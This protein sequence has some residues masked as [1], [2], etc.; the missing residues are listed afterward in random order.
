MPWHKYDLLVNSIRFKQSSLQSPARL[1]ICASIYL[2]LSLHQSFLPFHQ[3]SPLCPLSSHP[4]LPSSPPSFSIQPSMLSTLHSKLS[5]YSINFHHLVPDLPSPH[6]A[7]YLYVA[8]YR[9]PSSINS[10]IHLLI[11]LHLIQT[12]IIPYNHRSPS[13]C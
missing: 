10:F 13:S 2:S 6:Q 12:L 9:P 4:I 7:L 5:I 3:S 8:L 1:Y 11:F